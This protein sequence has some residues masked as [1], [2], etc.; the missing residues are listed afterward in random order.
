MWG[1]ASPAIM[2]SGLLAS[3][4]SHCR[5]CIARSEWAFEGLGLH[6]EGLIMSSYWNVEEMTA[7]Y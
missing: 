2:I 4:T 3:S 5:Q 6:V 7:K 1:T